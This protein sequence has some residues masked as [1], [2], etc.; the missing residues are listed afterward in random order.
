[1]SIPHLGDESTL[2]VY[3]AN[4]FALFFYSGSLHASV[5]IIDYQ[6]AVQALRHR[7]I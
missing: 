5:S 3:Y 2:H 1:M 7:K 6:A 4:F